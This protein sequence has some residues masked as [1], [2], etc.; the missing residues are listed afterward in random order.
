MSALHE[1]DGHALKNLAAA[2]R[3]GTLAAPTPAGL[4]SFCPPEL[5]AAV[6]ESLGGYLSRGFSTNQLA[7]LMDLLREDREV[8]QKSVPKLDLV[9]TGPDPEKFVDRDA[10][11]VV[12]DL[13]QTAR[14]SLIVSSYVVFNGV[15]LFEPLHRRME[16]VPGLEVF[17]FLDIQRPQDDS[18]SAAALVN[19]FK[20][21]FQ[22]KHW[23]WDTRP[24]V[25]FDPR[26]LSTDKATQAT[27][28]AKVVVADNETTLIT[29]ANLTPRAQNRNIEAGVRIES[30]AFAQTVSMQFRG[31]IEEGL[32]QQVGW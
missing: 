13:F 30:P 31:L 10:A 7:E 11:V 1:L 15:D 9:W 22:Q 5:A 23:P 18:R 19:A 20:S 14:R 12:M 32:V 8:S 26:S 24:E 21:E 25:Y 2:L 6:A 16:E 29:S 27:L 17:L 3:S 28:H 4:R